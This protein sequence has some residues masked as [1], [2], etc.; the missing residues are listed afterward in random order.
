MNDTVNEQA[1][2]PANNKAEDKSEFN[3][4]TARAACTPPKVFAE[5]RRQVE[6]DLKT[7]N[8]LRPKNAPYEFSLDGNID[9]FTVLLK[10]KD[11]NR[12]ITLKLA[13]QAIEVLDDQGNPM[14]HVTLTMNDQGECKLHA[15]EQEREYWQVRRMALEDLMF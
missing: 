15:N 8:D 6:E 10:A 12:S 9:Q 5:L 7:R 3:W 2:D 4:V 13:E 1:K 11:L 14:F